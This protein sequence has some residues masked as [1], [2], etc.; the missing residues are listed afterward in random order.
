V[1]V[2][3]YRLG[4][5]LCER[6]PLLGLGTN[7]RLVRVDR[8]DD[9]LLRA[10]LLLGRFIRLVFAP[11]CHVFG[12]VEEGEGPVGRGVRLT[13]GGHSVEKLRATRVLLQMITNPKHLC[14]K[15]IK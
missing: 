13:A 9:L 11:G 14:F 10:L 6:V 8:P 12:G 4:D 1:L 5:T 3:L 15:N 7:A 2:G